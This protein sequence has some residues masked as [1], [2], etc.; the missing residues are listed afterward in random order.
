MSYNELRNGRYSIPGHAYLITASTYQRCRLFN[1]FTLA[2]LL[3]GELIAESRRGSLGLLCWVIMP[4]HFHLLMV[5]KAQ[6]LSEVV[7]R[8]KGRAA[9]RINLAL[10]RRGKVWQSGY[11]DYALRD[12]DD[13]KGIARYM[14]ANPLRAGLVETV[15]EYPLWDAVWIDGET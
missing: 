5:L 12:G 1:D 14:V 7:N 8:I 15:R 4:D 2:R 13:V 11:Y 10:G 9:R 3:V 6:N